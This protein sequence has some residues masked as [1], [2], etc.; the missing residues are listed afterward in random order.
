MK[1]FI[2]DAAVTLRRNYQ[3]LPF[4]AITNEE[5]ARRVVDRA[6]STLQREGANFIYLRPADL[7]P[8]KREDLQLRRLLNTDPQSA[9]FCSAFLRADGSLCVETAGEDHLIISAYDEQGALSRCL[10]SALIISDAL[11]DS[12]QIARNEQF[13]C[14]TAFPSDAGS[15]LRATLTLHLPMTAL[16]RQIPG[17]LKLSAQGG[18]TLRPLDS[19]LFR[20]ENRITMG[21]DDNELVRLLAQTAEKLCNT[22]RELREAAKGKGDLLVLDA[23]WRAYGVAK[24]ARRLPR[25]EAMRLWSGLALGISMENMPYQEENVDAL[26]RI[27]TA[28]SENNS[29]LAPLQR[30]A[31]FADRV[32]ALFDGGN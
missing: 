16:R 30:D 32:R 28:P 31:L 23:A 21:M 24:S 5:T 12:G 7:H 17:A 13:G 3:D 1:D 14:L 26:Y 19:G 4:D 18:T 29:E 22:E 2:L 10:S 9:P 8:E 11:E 20:L 6:V 15:G 27:V 25:K